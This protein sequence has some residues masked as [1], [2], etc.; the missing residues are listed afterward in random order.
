MSDII[1]K[2]KLWSKTL[3]PLACPDDAPTARERL[4]NTFMNFRERVAMLAGE[5]HKDL[6]DYTVHDITHLDALWE[7]ADIIAGNDFFFTPTEA[8]VFGGA[9][10]LHDLGMGLASYAHGVDELQNEEIWA[11]IVTAQ[12]KD[13]LNRPPTK[14]EISNPPEDI[15]RKAIGFMLR[16][17]H[18][19]HAQNIAMMEWKAKQDDPSQ[20]LI[21][22][23]EIR[24]NFGRIIGLIAHSHWWP[25]DRLEKE[26]SRTLGSPH[27]CP[28]EWI[29]D[30]LKVACLLQVAD[31]SHIDARRAPSFL[32]AL[33]K[34]STFSSEHWRFQEKL[35]K[36][37]LAADALVYTSGYAF[38]FQDA[39]SWWLC[40]DTLNMIDR[41][42]RQVD[43]LLADKGLQ[44][45]AARRVAGVESPERLV[46][47]IPTEGWFPVNAIVQV[48]D[49][50]RLIRNLGGRELYG[51]KPEIALR[52]LI[53]NA[54]DAIRA[55]RFIENRSN[56]WGNIIVRLRKDNSGNWL[57]VEDNGVGMSSE[58]LTRHLLDFGVSYWGSSLM[59]DEFPGLLAS[60]IN[61]TGK[62]GI[63]F[64]SVFMIGQSVQIRTRRADAAQNET[65]V[66]EF[67]TGVTSRP[68]L[69]QALKNE[70]IRD[71]GTC[72]R[73]WLEK[74]PNEKD[75]LL[76]R[77]RDRPPYTLE[78]L[79]RILCPTIEINLTIQQDSEIDQIPSNPDWTQVNG[80][81][82]FHRIYKWDEY[83]PMIDYNGKEYHE[84]VSRAECNL[85][86]LINEIG[87][88]VGRACIV[89]QHW[90]WNELVPAVPILKGAAT[91]GGLFS[92]S[93]SG[94]AGFLTGTSER[95]A[96]DVAK[97][98]VS[99]AVLSSW[100]S[101]Q[102]D[103]VTQLFDEPEYQMSC[104]GVIRRCGGD[105]KNLP[106]A[107]FQGAWISYPEIVQTKNLP[108]E[109]ILLDP[110]LINLL[111]IRKYKMLN[112]LPNVI[113][114]SYAGSEVILQ[115][116]SRMRWPE[117]FITPW[118][119][120][121]EEYLYFQASLGGAVLEAAAKVWDVSIDSVLAVSEL[122]LDPTKTKKRIV[123]YIK[124]EAF[125]QYVVII[126]KPI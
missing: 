48:S 30:P 76:Y 14:N 38:P 70:R 46:S 54:A 58:V 91:I 87:E 55:R 27:W 51:L 99:A 78:K 77:D 41:E 94:I 56:D 111:G 64:F 18:A 95:A 84:F 25:V 119:E 85:R 116:R 5:I 24:Q 6:P 36:P 59:I 47:F 72:V 120:E 20:Y 3:A 28:N 73:V 81:D 83:Y 1:K 19:R 53:Q 112:F 22:D 89:L 4:R 114:V 45:F 12:F 16:C 125:E 7:M 2:T 106:I 44:R 61:P 100:A 8:F 32:R 121:Q 62:Y 90:G 82:F 31:A 52:E 109:I 21:D 39:F 93:L 107:Y 65:L 105:T 117:E 60:G 23:F 124:D 113:V 80:K 86:L 57:E 10:L 17:L 40:F 98:L 122:E 123:G 34:P 68:I 49:V 97:P 13:Q 11:D 110:L 101:E 50:P 37:H 118:K 33:R 103:L 71:G 42:L 88:K 63:G 66:L 126:R 67:N 26:F 9:I 74:P 75:G 15:K 29:V 96:R 92:C 102:A 43:T 115:S 69:R 79:C 104:A 35:Q 108:D